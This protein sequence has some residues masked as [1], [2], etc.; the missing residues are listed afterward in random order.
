MH[1]H[2]S[3][4]NKIDKFVVLFASTLHTVA[5]KLNSQYFIELPACR[6]YAW[7]IQTSL[8]QLPSR[9]IFLE[10]L[11]ASWLTWITR[12]LCNPEV[13]YRDHKNTPL[14]PILLQINPVHILIP[15][16]LKLH[17]ISLLPKPNSF[18]WCISLTSS[19]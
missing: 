11:T 16:L 17:S 13:H 2:L 15:Y 12:L 1:I 9:R 14:N 6:T 7:V 3:M 10:Q 18:K 5:G 8:R 4:W 19:D